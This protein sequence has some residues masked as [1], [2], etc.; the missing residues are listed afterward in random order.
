MG[1][2]ARQKRSMS[3]FQEL[4]VGPLNLTRCIAV[5]VALGNTADGKESLERM[6]IARVACLAQCS[7]C[8][9]CVGLVAIK[10]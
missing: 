7:R 6:I 3:L 1:S 9:A 8:K 5:H 4:Y 10:D 2:H